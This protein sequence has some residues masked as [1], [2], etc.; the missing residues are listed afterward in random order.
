MD[1]LGWAFGALLRLAQLLLRGLW[2]VLSV[3]AKRLWRLLRRKP[4]TF[5]RARFATNVQLWRRGLFGKRGFVFGK[6]KTWCGSKLVRWPDEG[7]VAIVAPPRMGKGATQITPNIL[8]HPGSMVIADPKAENFDQTARFRATLGPVYRLDLMDLAASDQLNPLDLVRVGTEHA[9]DDAA[10]LAELIVKPDPKSSSHWDV[11]AREFLT[12]MI[13]F[14]RYTK[15]P[16]L[17]TMAE[18]YG[19]TYANDIHLDMMIEEMQRSPFDICRN[20][21]ND[22]QSLAHTD[23]GRSVYSNLRKHM[24]IWSPDRPAAQLTAQSSFSL[25]SLRRETASLFV[26]VPAEKMVLYQGFLRMFTGIALAAMTREPAKPKHPVMFMLDETRLLGR[27]DLLPELVAVGAGYGV[28]IV[29]VWQDRQQAVELYGDDA[30]LKMS[31]LQVYLGVNDP[32]DARQLCDRIGQHTVRSRSEGASGQV[33]EVIHAGRTSGAS[34]AGRPLIYPAELMQS[35][36]VFA[37]IP[38]FPAIRVTPAPY[39]LDQRW[40]GLTD[41]WRGRLPRALRSER[42]EDSDAAA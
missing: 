3:F 40:R 20:V 19:L 38:K 22:M 14:L 18:L 42:K 8:E 33:E 41:L 9:V 6:R 37:F 31:G 4:G 29:T 25:E 13:L 36:D 34:E 17:C 27:L 7:H 35:H 39:Y 24:A 21:G 5:G 15:P 11:K 32:Q 2:L 1:F 12:A 23:E 26:I 30:I 28:Q 16:E 10:F